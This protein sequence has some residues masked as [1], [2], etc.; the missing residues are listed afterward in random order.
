MQAVV[1]APVAEGHVHAEAGADLDQQGDE[2]HQAR[3][4]RLKLQPCQTGDDV[5]L[6]IGHPEHRGAGGLG[7][8]DTKLSDLL[9]QL[10]RLAS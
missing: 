1:G 10:L 3:L 8:L 6:R 4:H 5:G 2:Q 7:G 9:L